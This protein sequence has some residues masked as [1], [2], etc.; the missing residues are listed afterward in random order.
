M[1][2][3]EYR[4]I[5]A[6]NISRL[7]VLGKS[8]LHY[9]YECAH[10]RTSDT[11]SLGTAAH[12][13]VLEPERFAH[14]FA[15]WD[16]VTDSGRMGPRSGQHWEK[17]SAAN[18]GKQI[19]TLEQAEVAS[20]V[21]HAVRSDLVARP[22]LETGEPEVVLQCELDGRQRKG[23]VDWVTRDGVSGAPVIV[24]L[25]SARDCRPFPFGSAS[26]RYGY[27]LQW[28]WYYDL[29]AHIKDQA[30]RM[31]EIVVESAPPY[32]TVVY[33]IPDDVIDQGRDEYERLLDLLAVC[34]RTG[35]WHGP[36]LE[37]QILSLPSWVYGPTDDDVSD[38]E[39]IA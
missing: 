28:A 7:K 34:E 15:V 16:R 12:C 11:L 23:R 33:R 36:A 10:P 22:Y 38:L 27:H 21:A 35:D 5:D 32:A 25:K 17:F 37:E 8:P 9:Q 2:A 29:F 20:A 13:A 6:L 19:I 4:A 3:E 31:I 26:A 1:P 18:A 30:P 39:L 14:Q 24:G